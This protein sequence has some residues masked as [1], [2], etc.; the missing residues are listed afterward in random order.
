M[1]VLSMPLIRALECGKGQVGV[2]W[3]V[4]T[5]EVYTN[6]YLSIK[7]ILRNILWWELGEVSLFQ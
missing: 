6:V 3:T 2:L 5:L 4:Y 7:T 1:H